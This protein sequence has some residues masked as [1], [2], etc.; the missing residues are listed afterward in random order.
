MIKPGEIYHEEIGFFWGWLATVVFFSLTILF[1][2]L[3]YVQRTYGPVGEN[4]AP[5]VLYIIMSAVFFIAG[6]L[7]LNLTRFTVSADARG[8][9]AGYGR[10]HYFVAWDNIESAEPDLRP[11]L[12]AFG[13]WGIRLGWRN[14][15]WMVVYNVMG[16]PLLCLKLKR[17][18]S[19][20]LG[21]STRQPDEMMELIKSWAK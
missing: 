10:F 5:D 4:P 3:L 13:G 18:K 7:M 1:L 11:A 6:L 12:L 15:G 19:R 16:A 20:Y 2:V 9:T 8:I 21:F 17:G 14:G